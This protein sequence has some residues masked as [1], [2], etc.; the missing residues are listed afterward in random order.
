ML[1]PNAQKLVDLGDDVIVSC[2]SLRKSSIDDAG[3][4]A[5]ADWLPN[6]AVASLT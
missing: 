2:R 6:T 1:R 5:I 3:A 4:Q